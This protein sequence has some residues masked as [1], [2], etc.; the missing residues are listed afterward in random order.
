MLAERIDNVRAGLSNGDVVGTEE[1]LVLQFIRS[2][3]Y[4]IGEELADQVSPRFKELIKITQQEVRYDVH[5][6]ILKLNDIDLS[7]LEHRAKTM[8]HEVFS[9]LAV[10]L[11]KVDPFDPALLHVLVAPP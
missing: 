6:S 7:A 5:L 2:K 11:E 1:I 3:V 8:E 9:T 4:E 10:D